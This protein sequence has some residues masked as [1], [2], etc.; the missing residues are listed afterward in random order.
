[1]SN[2][3][4]GYGSI[5]YIN[6]NNLISDNSVNIIGKKGQVKVRTS[7]NV[8]KGPSENY[9]VISRLRNNDI[10]D[11]LE[12]SNGWYKVKLSNES[13]GWA[14][15]D[16]ISIYA[17][18]NSQTESSTNNSSNISKAQAIVKT[19]HEQLGKPYVW[20]QKVQ[21]VLTARV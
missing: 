8:R 2:G 5:K 16:Y 18:S 10:V 3:I 1:M 7:L 20:V 19:A 21:I 9:A 11:L 13:T 4:I 17:G 14:S 12:K 6:V 15:G